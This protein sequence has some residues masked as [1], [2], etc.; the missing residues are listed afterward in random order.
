[1]RATGPQ[2]DGPVNQNNELRVAE[3]LQTRVLLLS[4]AGNHFTL[5]RV[6]VNISSLIEIEGHS[7]FPQLAGFVCEVMHRQL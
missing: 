7:F 4:G 6:K 5:Q 1:M 2:P 3:R